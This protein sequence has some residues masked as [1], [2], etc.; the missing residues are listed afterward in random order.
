[1]RRRFLSPFVATVALA[2][3][4]PSPKNPERVFQRDDGSCWEDLSNCPD[5]IREGMSCNPPPPKQVDC[6]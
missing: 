6:P 2:A 5:P 4:L 3:C 1:M